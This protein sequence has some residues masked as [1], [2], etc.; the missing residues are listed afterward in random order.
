MHV[1]V[2]I[3]L[4]DVAIVVAAGIGVRVGLVQLL[5]WAVGYRG[6]GRR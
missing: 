3:D 5:L 4:N 2:V 6:T 1:L